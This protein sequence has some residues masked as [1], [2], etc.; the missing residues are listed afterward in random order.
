M[1]FL[2]V[3]A[4]VR[5]ETC[6][7]AQS[8]PRVCRLRTDIIEGWRAW[9]AAHAPHHYEIDVTDAVPET[10]EASLQSSEAMPV[11]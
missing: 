4:L 5:E 7:R 3:G 2:D 6:L 9:D 8:C 11:G 10:V 1:G